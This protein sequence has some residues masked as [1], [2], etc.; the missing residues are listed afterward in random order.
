M[1]SRK[2]EGTSYLIEESPEIKTLYSQAIGVKCDVTSWDDQVAMFEAAVKA[3][4]QVHV[5]VRLHSPLV[6]HHTYENRTQI[7]NAGVNEIG[8]F[9]ELNFDKNGK[10]LPP[11]TKTLDINLTGV[12]YS[13]IFNIDFMNTTYL[14]F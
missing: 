6:K 14:P 11:S 7:P 2:L 3:F 10:P 1:T 12:L 9:E 13:R 5:V 4:G 8:N